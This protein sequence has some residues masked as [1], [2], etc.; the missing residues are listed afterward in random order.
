[1]SFREI[2]LLFPVSIDYR[3]RR[4]YHLR[5]PESGEKQET[6]HK[7]ETINWRSHPLV[8]EF[9]GSILFICIFIAVCIGAGVGFGNVG[10]GILAGGML[11]IGLGRYI[12]AT[13]FHLDD[14]GVTVRFFGQSRKV[15]WSEVRSICEGPKG[16]FL[17]PYEKP[18]SLDSFRGILLRYSNDN[19]D[20]VV[21]F[22]RDKVPNA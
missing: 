13:G 15:S 7:S 16:L 1:M 3:V 22:V 17:S 5:M 18:S 20:E 2:I 8:D 14:T 10:Y 6:A 12:L 4:C 11:L 21:K 19:S 9:P